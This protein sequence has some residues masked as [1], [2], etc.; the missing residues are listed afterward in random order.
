MNG[1]AKVCWQTVTAVLFLLLLCVGQILN[2]FQIEVSP[3]VPTDTTGMICDLVTCEDCKA[4]NRVSGI[5]A[6]GVRCTLFQGGTGSLGYKSCKATGNESDTCKPWGQTQPNPVS[7]QGN[8]F[9]CAC[10]VNSSCSYTGTCT[11]TGGEEDGTAN[12]GYRNSCI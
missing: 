11:C 8:Y 1:N 9:D 2:A 3:G 5:C 7:C 6:S 10:M 4:G 12:I